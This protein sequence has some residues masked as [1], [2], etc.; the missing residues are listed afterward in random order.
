[1]RES[2][3]RQPHPDSHNRRKSSADAKDNYTTPPSNDTSSS[4]SDSSSTSSGSSK[5]GS[6]NKD[7]LP[8]PIEPIAESLL[9]TPSVWETPSKL[10][11]QR[12]GLT[13]ETT[14][15][16]GRFRSES[17]EACRKRDI[18]PDR[19]PHGSRSRIEASNPSELP[20]YRYY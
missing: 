20:F 8:T 6:E 2:S 19:V 14:P 16:T 4:S 15:N 10:L 11:S 1:M 13:D 9:F 7:Y 17:Q 18:S 5:N 3:S 12:N